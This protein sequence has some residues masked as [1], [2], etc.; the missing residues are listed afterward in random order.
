MRAVGGRSY[1]GAAELVLPLGIAMSLMAFSNALLLYRLSTG[2]VRWW[3]ALPLLIPIE[4]AAL[5]CFGD[6]RWSSRGR[7]RG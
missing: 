3:G 2:R 7:W 4:A 1:Q 5:T 6:R